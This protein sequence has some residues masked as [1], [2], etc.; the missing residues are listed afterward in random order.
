MAKL[1]ISPNIRNSF[2][3]FFFL[4]LNY[5][6]AEKIRS[7]KRKLIIYFVISPFSVNF[8]KD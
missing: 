3:C 4:F 5:W 2:L 7:C 1:S 8:A 6:L